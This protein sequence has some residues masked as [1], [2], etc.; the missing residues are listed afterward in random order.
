MGYLAMG[1]NGNGYRNTAVGLA[2]LTTNTTGF[3]NTAVGSSAGELYTNITNAVFIGRGA[4]ANADDLTNCVAIGYSI[5]NTASDQVRIGNT[6]MNSI[7]GEV[8]WSTYADGRFKTDIRTEVPGLDFILRLQPVT[9][10]TDVYKL[11]EKLG[12]DEEIDENGNRVAKQLSDLER[13]SR[14]AKAAT[15][16]TGFIA[17]DVEAA[18]KSIGFDFSGVDAPKNEN[19]IYALRYA[20]FVVPL[21]KAIQEQQAMIEELKRRIEEL[22]RR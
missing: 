13:S 18:A 3:G 8:D 12:E 9:Y 1:N 16:Y 17:Q 10:K 7:G 22:E 14:N 11:A 2:S 6:Q 5:R 21:V 19:D 4:M 15:T 20:E